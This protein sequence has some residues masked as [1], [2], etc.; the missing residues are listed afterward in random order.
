MV[1]VNLTTWHSLYRPIF[2]WYSGFKFCSFGKSILD[3]GDVKL[4]GKGF[5]PFLE[6]FYNSLPL[7]SIKR[8]LS[9]R[10]LLRGGLY[11]LKETLMQSFSQLLEDYVLQR[12]CSGIL[13]ILCKGFTGCPGQ[14]E[15]NSG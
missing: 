10:D 1:C 14:T 9:G 3:N 6:Q 12:S 7:L 5:F 4:F 2:C 8:I 13:I 11:N 15:W